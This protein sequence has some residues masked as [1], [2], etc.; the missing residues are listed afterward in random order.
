MAKSR[1]KSKSAKPPPVKAST[2][3][4]EDCIKSNV[5]A[6][7]LSVS[8]QPVLMKVC[9]LCGTKDGPFLNI[10][11]P[12]QVTATK[13]DQLMPFKI[14]ENDDLPHKICFRCSAKVEELHEFV[15][16]CINTQEN[17]HSTMGKKA[18]VILKPKTRSVW[19]EKLNKS[20]MSNDD[21][22]DALIKRAME[23]IKDIPLKTLSL[24]EQNVIPNK[25]SDVKNRMPSPVST[26]KEE[27]NNP[28]SPDSKSNVQLKQVKLKI[29]KC[30]QRV[31]RTS[32]LNNSE[33][34]HSV[35]DEQSLKNEKNS[36]HL[37]ENNNENKSLDTL[38][39]NKPKS[40]SVSSLSIDYKDEDTSNVKKQ[41]ETKNSVTNNPKTVKPLF[42]IMDHVSMIK[43][44]GVGVLFQ[45]KLCNRNFLT[46]EV[47][48]SHA[49]AKNGI[50]KVDFTANIPPPEP[51][52]VTT[53]KYI[54]TKVNNELKKTIDLEVNTP[55]VTETKPKPRIGPASKIRREQNESNSSGTP[56]TD[57]NVPLKVSQSQPQSTV[58]SA[59]PIPNAAAPTINFPAMPSLQG[60]YKLMPGPNNTFTLVED[61]NQ[62]VS[63]DTQANETVNSHK[64]NSILKKR[65]SDDVKKTQVVQNN[66]NILADKQDKSRVATPNYSST[67]IDLDAQPDV[68]KS[69]SEQPYPV[70]LFQTVAHRTY[71]PP[72]PEPPTFT[73]PAMKKQSYTIVQTGNPSK[74]LIST[75][76]QPQAPAEEVPKKRSKKVKA[77]RNVEESKEPFSVTLEAANH[78]KDPGFFTFIN[79]DPLLQPSYV[80][81]TDNI[82]Q[83]SQISTSTSVAKETETKEKEKYSCNMC[84]ATFSRE[85][86][87]LTHIHSH[88]NKMDEEDQRRAEKSTTRKRGKR[89]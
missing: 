34:A 43:V 35:A 5:L 29:D 58:Q 3:P 26:L 88:Y 78:P 7:T 12:E 71:P 67:I 18:P 50:P 41:S 62:T 40:T 8:N 65:K 16:K 70:G 17:L 73:T 48:M 10:F 55:S 22:C 57:T 15:Q 72:L 83:E 21:I 75:K 64:S 45:C 63:S 30:D 20:N 87:L 80:L 69:T 25:K 66:S 56:T 46:K 86:K 60:R 76:P 27:L 1:K 36:P 74:L 81:P 49:C 84:N 42:N 28:T 89:N 52:K 85:K 9:R 51:P 79:V 32:R 39:N 44:N 31:T 11:D 37:S 38:S 24:D 77:D 53:V 47:V 68:E 19:E 59:T 2:F 54:N 4:T 14:A 82:I 61:I 13:V 6:A 33:K 23:G